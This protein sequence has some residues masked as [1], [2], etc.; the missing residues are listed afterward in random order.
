MKCPHPVSSKFSSIESDLEKV[1]DNIL[2]QFDRKSIRAFLKEQSNTRSTMVQ[3]DAGKLKDVYSKRIVKPL[4]ASKA[5]RP[6]TAPTGLLRKESNLTSQPQAIARGDMAS[7]VLVGKGAKATVLSTLDSSPYT[8]PLFPP[9][10]KSK[11]VV[12]ERVLSR[13]AKYSNPDS[14]LSQTMPV[15]LSITSSE[16]RA[17]LDGGLFRASSLSAMALHE[18]SVPSAREGW[19]DKALRPSEAMKAQGAGRKVHKF[20][21]IGH[22]ESEHEYEPQED[23]AEFPGTTAVS[24]GL[25]RVADS[26]C[27]KLLPWQVWTQ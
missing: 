8:Q 7:S 12:G 5:S 1:I 20:D 21:P 2:K 15:Q 25:L 10:I 14:H 13:A 22:L 19:V 9:A 6:G 3:K 24:M 17:E 18:G 16:D 23:S 11:V 26:L 27:R 4:E